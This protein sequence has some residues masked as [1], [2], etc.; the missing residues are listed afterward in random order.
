MHLL[1][2]ICGKFTRA[3]LAHQIFQFQAKQAKLAL[4]TKWVMASPFGITRQI[5]LLLQGWFLRP[6]SST[7]FE[8]GKTMTCPGFEPGTFEFQVGNV[9]NCSTEV[10]LGLKN[11]VVQKTVT[12]VLIKYQNSPLIVSPYCVFRFRNALTPLP[13][14]RVFDVA[15]NFQ[16]NFQVIFQYWNCVKSKYK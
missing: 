3:L 16:K 5:L 8:W 15:F 6:M 2:P 1:L 13:L 12:S 9:T 14:R 10:I 7:S 11:F 4:N